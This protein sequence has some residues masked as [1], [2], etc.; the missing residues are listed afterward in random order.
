[1][2]SLKGTYLEVIA[3]AHFK[4][5]NRR[6][7]IGKIK[8]DS[9]PQEPVKCVSA[10][11]KGPLPLTYTCDYVSKP[12]LISRLL[13]SLLFTYTWYESLSPSH[14]SWPI[15]PSPLC[16]CPGYSSSRASFPSAICPSY[17][18]HGFFYTLLIQ[19]LS[20][21]VCFFFF[22]FQT[23]SDASSSY[24]SLTHNRQLPLAMGW[25]FWWF[26]YCTVAY[27]QWSISPR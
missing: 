18:S 10:C 5:D 20:L 23:L 14:Q 3:S 25:P 1:M 16:Q 13:W 24:L 19:P 8:A 22:L 7:S 4:L 21:P 6:T 9:I 12:M 27:I 17:N 26:L 2:S 11:Q 15:L